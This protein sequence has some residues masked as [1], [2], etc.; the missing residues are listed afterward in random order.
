MLVEV[1]FEACRQWEKVLLT[2]F[3]FS[4]LIFRRLFFY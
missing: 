3:F 4:L 2:I 1:S